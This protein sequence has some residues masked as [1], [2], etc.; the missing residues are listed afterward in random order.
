MT[1]VLTRDIQRIDKQIYR[2][3]KEGEDHVK[4]EAVIGIMQPQAKE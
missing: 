3:E 4:T 1:S 2:R